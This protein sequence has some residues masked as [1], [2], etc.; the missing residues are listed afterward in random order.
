MNQRAV[1]NA[2]KKVYERHR[3][4]LEATAHG[5]FAVVDVSSEKVFT[6]RSAEEASRSARAAGGK[7]PFYLARIGARAAYRSRRV[8]LGDNRRLVH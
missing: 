3:A 8:S 1:V 4:Q 5:Q 7:G 2:G 6:A